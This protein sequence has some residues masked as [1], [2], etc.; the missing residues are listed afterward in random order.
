MT[1]RDRPTREELIE[2]I[3]IAQEEKHG[4]SDKSI[5]RDQ[6][7]EHSPKGYA[8]S[9]WEYHFGTFQEFRRQAGV[10]SRR[11]VDQLA[12]QLG[13][14]ASVDHF[15]EWNEKRKE[16]GERYIRK[17]KARYQTVL[18]FAD[19]H[20]PAADPFWLRV[21][22]ET[23]HRVQPNVICIAGDLFD[24]AEFSKFHVD[25]REWD[26][27]GHL[28]FIHDKILAPLRERCPKAQMDLIEGNHERRFL[29]HLISNSPATR[30]FLADWHG[31]TVPKALKLDD[32]EMNYVAEADL[33]AWTKREER[34]ELSKNFRIY[35]DCL[36]VHH[37]PQ[38]R[39]YGYPGFCGHNH[40]HE[41][42][43]S[44]SPQFGPYEW[45]Q[46]GCG[47]RRDANYTDGLKWSN[48][49]V[50]AHVDTELKEVL[51]EYVPVYNQAIV[52]GKF[53]YRAKDEVVL[54]GL[55]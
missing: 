26:V 52:G 53:Y 21:L 2:D 5:T 16:W 19:V 45:H 3:R 54:P 39:D 42:W 50:L 13:K 40:K 17:N 43:H 36:L 30:S 41:M 12:R 38:A 27:A 33:A 8:R 51:F 23:A 11:Q 14:H 49:F 47:H 28:S 46:I 25:P 44:Y 31:W 7:L 20:G 34:G 10:S 18:G 55:K 4:D 29:K 37:Y 6:Y 15:R 1:K 22:L 35:Y 48:G 32:Y 24:L 9:D